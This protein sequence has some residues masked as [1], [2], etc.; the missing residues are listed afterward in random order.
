[1]NDTEREI[2][3]NFT[4]FFLGGERF[5]RTSTKIRGRE[6]I[7]SKPNGLESD[8]LAEME[9]IFETARIQAIHYHTRFQHYANCLWD[10][11]LHILCC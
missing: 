4:C 3:N 9:T 5:R 10:E 2:L 6:E 11:P 7:Y 8:I 1:M